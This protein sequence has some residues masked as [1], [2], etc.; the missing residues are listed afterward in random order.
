MSALT[1]TPIGVVHS[2]FRERADAPRQPRADGTGE[3]E[4]TVELFAGR[5]FEDALSDLALWDHVWV[6]FWFDRNREFRP[7][8]QPPRSDVKRGLFATRSPYRP[9]P[10]GLSAL[11]L[12]GV[13]GLV[14]R[15][16]GLDLLDGTPVLD[17]KP[18]V[19][20]TD[21]IPHANHGWLDAGEPGAPVRD[22]RPAYAVLF[23]PR[24]Q[25]QLTFLR[26]LEVELEAPLSSALALGPSP[27]AYRRIKQDGDK[28]RIALKDWRAWFTVHERVITVERLGSGY[29]TR[30]LATAPSVHQAFAARFP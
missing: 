15:V 21:A 3:A 16:S 2:P 4:G 12:L 9:N 30:E 8:V 22:P 5:G 26:S 17:I 29:R 27:H 13:D 18:Y 1:I 24:A 19:P 11:R 7:K 28:L 6:V 23:S 25:E 10:I 20:Y 14:L